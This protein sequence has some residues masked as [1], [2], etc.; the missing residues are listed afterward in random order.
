MING[1]PKKFLSKFH[2]YFSRYTFLPNDAQSP[3]KKE[4]K[5]EIDASRMWARQMRGEGRG[6]E[7][8]EGEKRWKGGGNNACIR[9]VHVIWYFTFDEYSGDVST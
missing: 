7:G 2:N 8:R 3:K 4:E 5:Y 9:D 6:R 1:F